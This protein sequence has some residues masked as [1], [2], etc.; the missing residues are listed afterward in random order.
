M[1]IIVHRNYLV[2]EDL[3]EALEEVWIK[4]YE[5][6]QKLYSNPS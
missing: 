3:Q 4:C 6:E 5:L 1:N 2:Y